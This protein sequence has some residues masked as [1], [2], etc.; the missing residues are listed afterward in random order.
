MKQILTDL[1]REI[2]NITITVG[3]FNIL[4]SIQDRTTRQQINKETEELNNTVEQMGLTDLS[5]TFY[6]TVAEYTFFLSAYGHH[7][8]SI[9]C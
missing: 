3:G 9:P 6:P 4:L 7:P 5:R 2:D 8:G 1:K